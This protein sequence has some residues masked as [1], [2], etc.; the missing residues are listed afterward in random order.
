MS[1]LEFFLQSAEPDQIAVS[2]PL[3]IR[4]VVVDANALASDVYY[5]AA[6]GGHSS[7]LLAAGLGTIRLFTPPHIYGKVYAE[8]DY[9]NYEP[10]AE[11]RNEARRIWES[12]YLR[13]LRFV[14][15]TDYQTADPRVLAIA[16]KDEEDGP[17]AK[18]AALLGPC[19]LLS[20]DKHMRGLGAA[21]ADWRPLAVA[22][23]DAMMP[24]QAVV[25]GVIPVTAVGSGV[26]WGVGLLRAQPALRLPAALG[27]VALLGALGWR[28]SKVKN[29][30][31]RGEAFGN[32]IAEAAEKLQPV[33][34]RYREA[35]AR[36]RAGTVVPESSSDPINR[37]AWTLATSPRPLM[38]SELSRI[39]AVREDA[40]QL[41]PRHVG[42]VL[43]GTSCFR[44]YSDGRWKVGFFAGPRAVAAG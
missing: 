25:A 5:A 4:P 1:M 10:W 33:V 42:Q 39:L 13:K 16:S 15:V 12:E 26:S 20:E 44:T 37:V 14:D 18:L 27:G 28:L 31:E 7:M 19:I 8:L 22:S 3:A 29:W 2:G 9:P 6:H 34:D 36:L 41:S 30:R 40:V 11:L 24:T 21:G 43:R 35:N 38:M 23:R 32:F 17:V